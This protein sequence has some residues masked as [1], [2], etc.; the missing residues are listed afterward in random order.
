MEIDLVAEV[1]EAVGLSETVVVKEMAVVIEVI[2]VT[3]GDGSVDGEG[4]D[5][6]G[7]IILA[8]SGFGES[9]T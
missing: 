7:D 6:R 3:S 8:G 9:Y 4:G 5:G 1:M 2:V